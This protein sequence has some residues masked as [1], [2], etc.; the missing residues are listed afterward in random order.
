M[1]TKI[2]VNLIVNLKIGKEEEVVEGEIAKVEA[3]V[4]AGVRLHVKLNL[5]R[6]RNEY[7]NEQ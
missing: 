4:V 5:L 1:K 6:L 7:Y 3:E 2:E